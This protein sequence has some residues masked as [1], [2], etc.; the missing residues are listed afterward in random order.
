LPPRELEQFILRINDRFEPDV[1][2]KEDNIEVKLTDD[3]KAQGLPIKGIWSHKDKHT[4]LLGV[5]GMIEVGDVY[6]LNTGQDGVIEQ[7]TQ[8]PDVEHDDE[9]DALVIALTEAQN[10]LE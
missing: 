9:M 7:I 10:W 6:F 1:I 3:L 5:A 2:A 8:Y 4:R